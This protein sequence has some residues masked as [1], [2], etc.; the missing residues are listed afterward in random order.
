MTINLEALDKFSRQFLE[1]LCQKRPELADATEVDERWTS[2]TKPLVIRLRPPRA[3]LPELELSS[4]NDEVT[5]WYDRWHEHF[6]FLAEQSKEEGFQEALD[7]LDEILQERVAVTVTMVGDDWRGS[8]TWSPGEPFPEPPPGGMTY[9]RS[10]K[11]T[12]NREEHA[13]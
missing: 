8:H 6:A 12:F 4:E 10:W 5:L 3:E 9:M 7:S 11:G 13:R 2:P 1:W